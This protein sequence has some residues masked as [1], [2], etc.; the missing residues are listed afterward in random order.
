MLQPAICSATSSLI[1]TCVGPPGDTATLTGQGSAATDSNPNPASV[2]L[3]TDNSSDLTIDF[4]FTGPGIIGDFVWSDLNCNGIQDANEPGIPGVTRTSNGGLDANWLVKHG[5]PT[6]TFGA[7][8][9]AI[10]TV[11]EWVDVP[12]FLKGCR[13]ALALA[14]AE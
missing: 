8:Q 11:D 7:G 14:T 1:S 10:H 9:N 12:L 4:G 2:T 6:V 13:M 3:L 5:I